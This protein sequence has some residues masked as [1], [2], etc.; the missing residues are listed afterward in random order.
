MGRIFLR[1][2]LSIAMVFCFALILG[3]CGSGGGGGDSG[4][5]SDSHDS[6]KLSVK[7][8]DAKPT[9]PPGTEKVL[10]TFD[11]VSVC[12]S[13]GDDVDGEGEWISLPLPHSPYTID[14]LQFA[15]GKTTSLV[16]PV[17][18]E[19]G[20]YTQIRIGV[21]SATIVISG[22][23]YS[24]TIPSGNLKT[25]KEF[26]FM[27][28]GGGAVDLIVDFD[29]S[30]SIVVTGSGEFKLKPILHIVQT[31]EA[32]TIAGQISGATFGAS[33]EA[34]VIVT[35]DRDNSGSLTPGDEEYTKL[36]VT[37]GAID[38]TP[39][40]V[41]WLVPNQSYVVQ[42]EINGVQVYIEA[43]NSAAMTPGAIVSLNG[44]SPI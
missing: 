33:I 20:H 43:L 27:V 17:K 24:V 14:L 22:V 13:K 8:T 42:I 29:L 1:E 30:Q 35:W 34:T 37:K 16:P 18:L 4:S 9:L 10:I 5:H 44:G 40:N 19:T 3:S 26:D 36:S 11:S 28:T 41:F 39:F 25:D 38:P 2:A 6:G 21:S 7:I 23:A 15:D 31:M 12:K 32:A